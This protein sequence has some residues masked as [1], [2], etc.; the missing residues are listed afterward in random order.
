MLAN[1]W[2]IALLICM[3]GS[4]FLVLLAA[5][6]ALRILLFWDADSDAER[7]VDLEGRVWLAAALVESALGVQIFSLILLVLAADAF[8]QMI[9]GAMCATGSF[10][11]NSYGPTVLLLKLV[12]AFCSGFWLVLHRL[13]L[14]SE[15]FPLLRVKFCCVMLLLP[16]LVADGYY[17]FQY[18]T[19][20]EPDIITSCCGVI[21]ASDALRTNFFSIAMAP[22]V[23]LPLFYLGSA[24]LMVGGIIL[25]RKVSIDGH[26]RS[27]YVM[28]NIAPNTTIVCI[29]INGL[30]HLLFLILALVAVT[31]FF[32]SYIY[33]MPYHNCPFDILKAEYNFIG[34]PIY[35][36]L[37]GASFLA[38][39]SAVVAPFHARPGLAV[40]MQKYQSVALK[41]AAILL[42]LFVVLVTYPYIRYVI[43]GGE[44]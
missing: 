15:H 19:H 43:A 37:F 28:P 23:L 42:L 14:R 5:S 33:A 16:L 32:S 12:G 24:L 11:A 39:S 7:Q 21:F 41:I 4:L 8:S 44:I 36:A 26:P 35:F 1:S 29:V 20:L 25:G 13:D 27:G 9:A 6:T 3:A 34:F 10:L 22:Q 38:I 17:L 31:I 30:L 18:L 40:A 2:S